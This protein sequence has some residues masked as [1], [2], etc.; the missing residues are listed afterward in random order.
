MLKPFVPVLAALALSAGFAAPAA[1]ALSLVSTPVT[2]QSTDIG[3]TFGFN[4]NGYIKENLQS[5]LSATAI[6]KLSSVSADNK[7]WNFAIDKLSNTSSAPITGS[8]V[9]LFAF[10]VDKT[11]ASASATGDF[12]D[13]GLTATVP[14]FGGNEF[15]VCYKAGGGGGGCSGGGGGG[16]DQ[17]DTYIGGTFSMTF[18]NAVNSLKLDNFVVRYQSIDGPGF[19]GESGVGAVSGVVPEPGSWA[20]MIAGFGLAGAAMRRRRAVETQAA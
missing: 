18:A 14:Q 3:S 16:V 17:G 4:F 10:N 20:M 5:G 8:R 9:S 2:L 7:T 11:I 6:F 13:I 15:S 1:A 12:S 19:R